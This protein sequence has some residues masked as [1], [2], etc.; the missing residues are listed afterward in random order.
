MQQSLESG[1]EEELLFTT[2]NSIYNIVSSA[3]RILVKK[4]VTVEI[5]TDFPLPT[6]E[7]KKIQSKSLWECQSKVENSPITKPAG[8]EAKVQ[9]SSK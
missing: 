3:I 8:L 9:I 7:K 5:A 2:L 6:V 1:R 4:S